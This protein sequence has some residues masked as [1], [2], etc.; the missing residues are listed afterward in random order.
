[1]RGLWYGDRRDRV[2]WGGLIHLAKSYKIP[3][4]LQ[5]AYLRD[6]GKMELRIGDTG[7]TFTLQEEVWK[8]F[9]DL[10]GIRRLGKVV[11]VDIKVLQTTFDPTKRNEY[12]RAAIDE[13]RTA[14]RP[15]V[16]FL[17]PDTGISPTK[18]AR[19]EHVGWEDLKMIWATLEDG[20]V[21]AIYQ[22]ADR[23]INWIESRQ[24]L[25]NE[26]LGSTCQVICGKEIAGDVALLW[27]RKALTRAQGEAEA[28]LL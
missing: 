7:E 11:D 13:L 25:L 6:S 24:K 23:T 21:L 16:A 28:A 1:M 14:S 12:V 20:D 18:K 17:D 4:I 9:S 22:H 5:I 10:Q 3:R 19:P 2:K 26:F 8:H 27:C 15:L